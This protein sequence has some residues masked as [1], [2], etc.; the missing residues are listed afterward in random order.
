MLEI[1]TNY[2]EGVFQHNFKNFL[3]F[4]FQKQQILLNESTIVN[5]P[6]MLTDIFSSNHE[7]I[8]N[9][10]WPKFSVALALQKTLY[11]DPVLKTSVN[12]I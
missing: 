11:E 8:I 6:H 5:N 9:E 12:K 10:M 7:E 1:N 2:N 4:Y 3:D